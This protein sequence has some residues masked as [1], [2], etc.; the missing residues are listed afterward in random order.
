MR[1]RVTMSA[2]SFSALDAASSGGMTNGTEGVVVTRGFGAGG[3]SVILA[4]GRGVSVIDKAAGADAAAIGTT[5]AA[6]GGTT[7]NGLTISGRTNF[8][9]SRSSV[10]SSSTAASGTWSTDSRM[11]G[12][13]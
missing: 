7:E 11:T 10:S 4:A 6:I 3:G 8:G 2:D 9:S 12:S 13:R 1:I 5:V